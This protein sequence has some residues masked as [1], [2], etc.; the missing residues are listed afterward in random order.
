MNMLFLGRFHDENHR[1]QMKS[2]L[3]PK[4][5]NSWIFNC[6]GRKTKIRNSKVEKTAKRGHGGVSTLHGLFL[7]SCCS[8][9]STIHLCKS[10]NAGNMTREHPSWDNNEDTSRNWRMCKSTSTLNTRDE[11]RG[12]SAIN[13]CLWWHQHREPR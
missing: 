10:E 1:D 5:N 11:G 6:F 2:F 8:L 13:T 7:K 3:L 9:T 4:R 12:S